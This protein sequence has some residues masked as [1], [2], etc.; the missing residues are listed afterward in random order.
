MSEE[1]KTQGCCDGHHGCCNGCHQGAKRNKY[2]VKASTGGL[3]FFMLL[4]YIG[5]AVYF[6]NQATDFWTGVF[7]LI[8]AIV[9]PAFVI[10]QVLAGFNV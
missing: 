6:M 2:E 7:A 10:Y 9:W 8:K 5:A 1:N 3:G 4:A